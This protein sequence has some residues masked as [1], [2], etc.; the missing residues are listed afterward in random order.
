M[1]NWLERARGEIWKS[2]DQSTDN[3]DERNLTAVSAVSRLDKPGISLVEPNDGMAAYYAEEI[4]LLRHK[5]MEDLKLIH[6]TKLIF[7]G[8][9]V[10][11]EGLDSAPAEEFQQIDF[12]LKA[13]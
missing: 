8:A 12:N 11:Q 1:A 2:A 9:R 10:I 3:T 6:A 5:S 7:P 4:P 13:E